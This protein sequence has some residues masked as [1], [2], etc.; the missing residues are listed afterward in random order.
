M[1][2]VTTDHES[3]ING[4][5]NRGSDVIDVMWHDD[6][7]GNGHGPVRPSGPSDDV[8]RRQRA[9]TQLDLTEA[10]IALFA[11]L[12][13]VVILHVVFRQQSLVG[14][15]VWLFVVFLAVYALLVR[16]RSDTETAIDRVVTVVI[17]STG[18]LVSAVLAW[19]MVYLTIKG[20]P[21]L[22]VGFFT[23]DL[24]KVGPLDPGGGAKHAVIGTIEQVGIATVVVVPIALLT[25]IYLNE[26]NGRLALPVRFIVDA[27]SGLPSI[28][29]GLLVFTVWVDGHGYSGIAGSAALVV[30]MLPTVTR[31]SEEILRTIPDPLREGGLAL[32]APQWRL[33]TR[34]VVPTALAGLMTAVILGIA[35]AV[36]ETAPMLLTAF[37]SDSTNTS[38]L[39]G[40]QADLPLFVWKLI[41]LPNAQQQQRA[42]TGALILVMLVLVLFVTAR[43]IASRSQR[44][45]GGKR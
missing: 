25:A 7:D 18:A 28:V 12:A 44:K 39:K 22:R 15:A 24:S 38:P 17:W 43:A 9:F 5:G 36:G 20:L 19:M 26:I 2:D 35:R 45:L 6:V 42:W 8:P 29:A 13:F 3:G 34:V 32:G 14:A 11:S 30:L 1:R 16:D 31:T 4:S 41:G 21:A 23:D 37:G 33:I 40:P 27:M 10:L